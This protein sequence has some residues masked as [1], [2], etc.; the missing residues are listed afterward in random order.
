MAFYEDRHDFDANYVFWGDGTDFSFPMH[1][2][3][4]PEVFVVTSGSISVIVEDREYLLGEGDSVLIWSH[5]VHSYRT[6][7]KSTHELCIFAPEL[8][9]RFFTV[10]AST[11]PQTPVMRATDA[12]H[13]RKLI[14][15]LKVERD[16][17]AVK[18]LLYLLCGEFERCLTFCERER[19]RHETGTALLTQILSYVNDNY[20][21]D[22]SLDSIADALRY[23]KTYISK[24]FSRNVGITL[25]EYIL[26]LRLARACNLLLNTDENI[27]DVGA[28][29]GFNSSRTFNRNFLEHYGVTPSRYRAQKGGTITRVTGNFDLEKRRLIRD[30]KKEG[31][32]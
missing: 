13:V 32:K 7:A 24:F 14:D 30:N 18:G 20:Q 2:H 26:Q 19:G 16:I 21:G 10:H 6:D 12:P 3:R 29:S 27:I 22:C 25:A 23:E 9:Q 1:V 17:F 28:A 31:T 8:V 5:Q 11:I 4:C 15:A